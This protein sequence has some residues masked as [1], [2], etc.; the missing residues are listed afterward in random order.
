MK[1]SIIVVLTG[2]QVNFLVLVIKLVSILVLAIGTVLDDLIVIYLLV[3]V[4]P[5]FKL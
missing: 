1:R 5:L 4:H 2:I 3:S